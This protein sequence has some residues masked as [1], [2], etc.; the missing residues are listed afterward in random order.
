MSAKFSIMGAQMGNE[1]CE[2]LQEW[3]GVKRET[4]YRGLQRAKKRT[5]W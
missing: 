5:L 4:Y 3:Y 2:G 1:E